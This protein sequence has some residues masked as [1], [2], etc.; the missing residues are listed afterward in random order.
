MEITRR[1]GP[2]LFAIGPPADLRYHPASMA[3]RV[4]ISYSHDSQEH[5]DRV[6]QLSERLRRDGVDCRIDQHGESSAVGTTM[7]AVLSTRYDS[8]ISRTCTG[9]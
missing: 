1:R 7:D 9:G 6:W 2:T 8:R 5:M 3:P 4:F